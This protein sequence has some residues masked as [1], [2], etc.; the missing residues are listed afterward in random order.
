ASHRHPPSLHDAL[1]ILRLNGSAVAPGAPAATGGIT[2]PRPD[3]KNV[4][5]VPRSAGF[6]AV[7]TEPLSL[8]KIP[9]PRPF[10]L[11]VRIPGA[12]ARSEE[13]TSELQSPDHLV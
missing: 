11:C 9:G 4:T 1:P 10:P 12:N 8:I 2:A 7:T 13:H 6:D 5:R 3:A